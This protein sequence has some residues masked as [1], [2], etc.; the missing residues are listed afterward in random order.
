VA[1]TVFERLR[2]PFPPEKVYQRQGPGGKKLDFVAIE[3]VLERLLDV[4][5]DYSW[6]ATPELVPVVKSA[7]GG[8]EG[9]DTVE[10]QA[11]TAVVTGHLTIEGKSAFGVGS[12][13]NPDLDMALKSA[14]S[15]AMKNAAKNGFGVMLELWNEEYRVE[16][17][18]RRAL[19]KA[20]LATLKAE[21]YKLGR[22]AIG[23]DKPTA[24]E[25]AAHFGVDASMLTDEDTLRGI[26]AAA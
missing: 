9:E 7:G 13:T 20:S 3:T 14:N 11:Y 1:L 26:L 17:G 24:K 15:E 4:A 5:P 22:T 23:K 8:D 19:G 18:K 2:A 21:V 16:L 6:V 25:I 12:H 10:R